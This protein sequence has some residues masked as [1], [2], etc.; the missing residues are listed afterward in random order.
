MSTAD[1]LT[2]LLI[3]GLRVTDVSIGTTK[4]LFL[5][6]GYRIL[7]PL[8]SF[9][10]A[11]VWLLATTIVFRNLDS[12]LNGFAFASGFAAG[13]VAGMAIERWVGL[14]YTLVRIFTREDPARITAILRE[15]NFG[16]TSFR[17]AGYEG[18]LAVLLV[19]TTPKQADRLI[20]IIKE[21]DPKVFVTVDPVRS[22]IG[23][24][25]PMG[26]TPSLLR[27]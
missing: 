19:V 22:V 5:V 21:L 26:R 4:L 14:G 17:A 25:S 12:L 6:R 18:E 16:M 27:K 24:Y 2:A 23:G 13:T 9:L 20:R 10:E 1:F 8:L 3:F 15:S 7:T 11:C